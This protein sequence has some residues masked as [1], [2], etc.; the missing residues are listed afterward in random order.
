MTRRRKRIIKKIIKQKLYGL[1]AFT[2]TGIITFISKD[3]T[4]AVFVIIL[5]PALFFTIEELEWIDS[6]FK[7]KC[8][9][10]QE[11]KKYGNKET[12]ISRTREKA[13]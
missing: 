6:K 8:D 3:I 9:F 2:I 4:L 10:K 12:G 5:S 1:S 13:S 11:V 7:H